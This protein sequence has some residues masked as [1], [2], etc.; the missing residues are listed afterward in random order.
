MGGLGP[1][2]AVTGCGRG[3][4][5]RLRGFGSQLNL[6]NEAGW[7][8]SGGGTGPG[9]GGA[10]DLSFFHGYFRFT[11][12]FRFSWDIPVVDEYAIYVTPS[13]QAGFSIVDAGPQG[14]F[15]TQFSTAA[16]VVINDRASVFFQPFNMD[17]NANGD[18]MFI[19]W[20]VLVGGGLTF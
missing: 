9:I 3:G 10:V 18:G 4:C 17:L 12:G 11:P 14:F 8:L 15:N 1:A 20:N 2:F 6:H 5:A 16:R 7:H 13:A 19:G